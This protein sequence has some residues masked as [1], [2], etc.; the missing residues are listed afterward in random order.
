MRNYRNKVWDEIESFEAF[1]IVSIPRDQNTRA[2][3]LAVSASLLL[4]HSDFKDQVYRMEVLF[5]PSV[6]DNEESWQVFDDDKH[7]QQF[8]EGT[9]PFANLCF[10]SDQQGEHS[11]D[12]ERKMKSGIV[13]LKGNRIPSHFV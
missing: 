12:N 10:E 7:I 5:R 8:I 6:P 13:Q 3:S 2:D 4:P 11:S 9:G 1:S